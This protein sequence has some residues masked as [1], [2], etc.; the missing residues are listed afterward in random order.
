MPAP[1]DP[2]AIC[3]DEACMLGH[4]PVCQLEC[5]HVFHAGCV[6][7]RVAAGFPGPHISFGFLDCALCRARIGPA[8]HPVFAAALAPR[9]AL[10][11]DLQRKVRTRLDAESRSAATVPE[12]AEKFGGDALAWGL[13]R[14][15]YYPCFKCAKP[16]FGGMREC[17][18]AAPDFDPSELV[19]P[20]CVPFGGGG[21]CAK[22]GDDFMQWKCRFCCSPAVF[23]CGAIHNCALCHDKFGEMSGKLTAKTL[24]P[25]PAAPQGV[26]LPPDTP[27]PLGCAHPP[28]GEEMSLGCSLCREATSF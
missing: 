19:C 10:E 9:L 6:A 25:C 7:A 12:I 8:D 24:P 1:T 13:A 14:Y 11:A 15:A 17:G 26:A 18:G 2:C 3:F 23:L 27:C 21:S 4:A 5:G 28:P 16:F 20:A 22:H